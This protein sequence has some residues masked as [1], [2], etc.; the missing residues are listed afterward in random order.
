MRIELQESGDACFAL[1]QLLP[2]WIALQVDSSRNKGRQDTALQLRLALAVAAIS[3][4]KVTTAR[5]VIGEQKT[6]RSIADLETHVLSGVISL[7]A[8]N[9]E[10]AIRKAQD[11]DLFHLKDGS[12]RQER[13]A[14]LWWQTWIFHGT[15]QVRDAQQ[16]AEEAYDL[17][18]STNAYGYHSQV[19]LLLV[20]CLLQRRS[21][22]RAASLLQAHLGRELD[23]Q[24]Q[25]ESSL[26]VPLQALALCCETLILYERKGI[27]AACRHLRNNANTLFDANST[28]IVFLSCLAHEQLFTLLCKGIGVERLPTELTDLLDNSSFKTY[29]QLAE[30]QLHAGESLKLRT[31]FSQYGTNFDAGEMR[32]KPVEIR[33]FGG[34]DISVAGHTLDLR[35]WGNSKTRSLF[36]SLVLSSG[37]E[38][39]REVL[40]ERLWPEQS[41]QRI[42]NTYNVTWW[43]MRKR[44]LDAL[45]M[46]SEGAS[47]II[48]ESFQNVGGRCLLIEQN[49]CIDVREFDSLAAE[50]PDKLQSNKR[51]DC[52][53]IVKRMSD[54]YRGDLLPGD[55]YLE[56]LDPER[57][58]Y[59]K[60]FHDA[61]LLA[62]EICLENNQAESALFYLY[63]ID[64][65]SVGSEELYYLRMKAYSAAGR[66]EDAM[67]TFHDC[68]QFL[69]NE[70]GLD[71]SARI[72]DLHQRL[73]CEVV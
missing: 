34:L 24:P 23:Q 49:I 20:S 12:C 11:G 10:E 44:I 7:C 43:Q 40:A 70:L 26:S 13:A 62:A 16:K 29:Y 38:I 19:I 54:I 61:V 72:A 64:P 52:L 68:R 47:E 33:L 28:L 60:Q 53:P 5:D 65:A 71:P 1:E 58:H 66:R 55:R 56:W 25:R 37:G 30:K 6:I 8:G 51:Q 59:K 15:G 45:P 36:I 41:S 14:I 27:R 9:R 57:S 31:R 17:I 39:A 50:L 73:L 42:R 21:Y 4:G 35:N 63:R 32:Q 2:H 46:R 69:Q 22:T 67:Q 48:E 18:L 3:Q